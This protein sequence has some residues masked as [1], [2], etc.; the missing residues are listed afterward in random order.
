M[1]FDDYNFFDV[2]YVSPVIFHNPKEVVK[3]IEEFFNPSAENS[4][5]VEEGDGV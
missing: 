3:R 1:E 4:R 2:D 5:K